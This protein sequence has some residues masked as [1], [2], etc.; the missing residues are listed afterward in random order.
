MSGQIDCTIKI[1][2]QNMIYVLKCVLTEC[3][4]LF[5]EALSTQN[6]HWVL[7]RIQHHLDMLTSDKQNIKLWEKRLTI[8]IQVKQ[9]LL[10]T[11][12]VTSIR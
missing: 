2:I 6:F 5:S 3:V 11:K 10:Q 4:I 8:A 1:T 9:K 12:I 7:G